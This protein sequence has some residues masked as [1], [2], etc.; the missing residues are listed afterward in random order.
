MDL[1]LVSPLT[2]ASALAAMRVM[3]PMLAMVVE[4]TSQMEPLVVVK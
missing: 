4:Q 3:G 2:Q 1:E